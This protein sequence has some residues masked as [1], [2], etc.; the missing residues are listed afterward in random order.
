MPAVCRSRAGHGPKKM[1]CAMSRQR[2]IRKKERGNR[3]LAERLASF[4]IFLLFYSHRTYQKHVH[5]N[6]AGQLRYILMNRDSETG[7]KRNHWQSPMNRFRNDKSINIDE[8]NTQ[9]RANHHTHILNLSRHS[10]AHHLITFYWSMRHRFIL[11]KWQTT[12]SARSPDCIHQEANTNTKNKSFRLKTLAN[13]AH[14][15]YIPTSQP[16]S[17]PASH[18]RAC[19]PQRAWYIGTLLRWHGIAW[20]GM[21]VASLFA[22]AR[23]NLRIHS[24]NKTCVMIVLH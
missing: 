11:W 17:Q 12:T 15:Q 3:A 13:S 7:K 9:R 1:R 23:S 2:V 21:L 24:R 5:S 18:Q 16:V 22:G 14:M 8:K 10:S 19:I 20:P 4:F 6:C